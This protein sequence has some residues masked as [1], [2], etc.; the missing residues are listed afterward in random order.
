MTKL[1][2]VDHA[3]RLD[4][5]QTIVDALR[6]RGWGRTDGDDWSLLWS[7]HPHSPAVLHRVRPDQRINHFPGVM[8]LH[9]KDHLAHHLAAH[10]R[11]RGLERHPFVPE[12]HLLP[13]D[14]DRWRAAAAH[15]PDRPWIVKPTN[16]M[17]GDGIFLVRGPDASLPREP[18]WLVQRYIDEPLLLPGDPH[19]HAL[20]V[21][22]VVTAL[23]PLTAYIHPRPIVKFASRPFSLAHLH[24]RIRHLTN[25][26]VQLTNADRP[27]PVRNMSW[28]DYTAALSGMGVDPA[29]VWAAIRDL[30]ATTLLAHREPMRRLSIGFGAPLPSCF[31]LLGF[32]LT[33]DATGQPWLLE[34]NASPGIS[35]RGGAGSPAQVVQRTTK[36]AVLADLFSLIGVDEGF[37]VA[38]PADRRSRERNR[39]G[40]FDTLLPA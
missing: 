8:S 32:D 21:F 31:D 11:A 13:D 36:R 37:E 14:H 19:K 6:P 30:V 1:V 3:G 5:A 9:L 24:D 38:S 25:P 20:R 10:A 15:E 16:D 33:L 2:R 18:G 34:C 29:R 39:R 17:S 26:A 22:V 12:T 35:A 28:E 40:S 4:E 27:D 7:F 23:D